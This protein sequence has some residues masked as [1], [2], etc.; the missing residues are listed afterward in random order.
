METSR[1]AMFD[2][3][4]KLYENS[5]LL[6]EDE[7]TEMFEDNN[8]YD[9]SSSLI[10]DS[11][12]TLADSDSS[13]QKKS[14]GSK[15]VISESLKNVKNE[16]KYKIKENIKNN[17]DVMVNKDQ[18]ILLKEK[19][20]KLT[21]KVQLLQK[22]QALL[23]SIIKE[24]TY[25]SI[26]ESKLFS[27]EYLSV[28]K[29]IINLIERDSEY[30]KKCEESLKEFIN[31]TVRD[32]NILLAEKEI[33]VV[34]QKERID[35]LN[36]KIKT[37]NN[38][39]YEELLSD[40]MDQMKID[41][42]A[43]HK[44]I[45]DLKEEIQ[46]RDEIIGEIQEENQLYHNSLEN[47]F[48]GL[49]QEEQEKIDEM[50]DVQQQV[51][52]FKDVYTRTTEKSEQDDKVIEQLQRSL[53]FKDSIIKELKYKNEEL[54][55]QLKEKDNTIKEM[56]E[57][58]N[59]LQ[60]QNKM[61]KNLAVEIRESVSQNKKKNE[62][63]LE[64]LR[65]IIKRKDEALIFS[66]D[67]INNL[68][69]TIDQLNDEINTQKRK[70]A[71]EHS[72]FK[73]EFKEMKKIMK[74]NEKQ[75]E[76][77]QDEVE[78]NERLYRKSK[79]RA[80]KYKALS[81]NSKK[82]V[83]GLWNVIDIREKEVDE[84][85]KEKERL[86]EE[87]KEFMNQHAKDIEYLE[88]VR[89]DYE[90]KIKLMKEESD[91]ESKKKIEMIKKSSDEIEKELQEQCTNLTME[92][93]SLKNDLEIITKSMKL[94]KED[95]KAMEENN[96]NLEGS[97][98][99]LE[100]KQRDRE[101]FWK[102]EN[103]KLEMEK[104]KEIN[105]LMSSNKDLE[106]QLKKERIQSSSLAKYIRDINHQEVLNIKAIQK[107]GQGK[108]SKPV[109]SL[110]NFSDRVELYQ[111]VLSKKMN[112]DNTISLK[113]IKNNQINEKQMDN[114]RNKARNAVE[115]RKF[116]EISRERAARMFFAYVDIK[117]IALMIYKFLEGNCLKLGE[118]C[119][120]SSIK[121]SGESLVN[122]TLSILKMLLLGVQL[123]EIIKLNDVEQRQLIVNIFKQ[124]S[125]SST[126]PY[127]LETTASNALL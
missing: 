15:S 104:N 27:E 102:N 21:S 13:V 10:S 81:A 42:E 101:E 120:S 28:D 116:V 37:N 41:E 99:A 127:F 63:D 66:N 19:L 118:S 86:E 124:N 75:I 110:K 125:I 39:N 97:I 98:K 91:D 36:K 31:E 107:T 20:N 112:I 111:K 4:Q 40:M 119:L 30:M 33:E 61:F 57:K 62:R 79:E 65:D 53:D 17:S 113:S 43:Y 51:I 45:S 109:T 59:Y 32:Y 12:G 78:Y 92:K 26:N 103:K 22:E 80:E 67:R 56:N 95:S 16:M 72:Q 18:E 70:L 69:E 114:I 52:Y 47:L 44:E 58:Y 84:L 108:M 49:P 77:L 85:N 89:E 96:K 35:E 48:Q 29:N 93:E 11:D 90:E 71:D 25:D 126:V 55:K 121:E 76:T 34:E 82:E 9:S 94:I 14:Q 8:G 123:Y 7:V 6:C 106:E 23:I 54:M 87:N 117:T 50:E 100:R 105:V 115:L 24:H 64:T 73:K 2:E 60:S 74:N 46:I 38:E 1:I 88:K 68:R 5:S 122:T 3:N 83:N